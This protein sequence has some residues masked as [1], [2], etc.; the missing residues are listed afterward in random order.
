M[1]ER[2]RPRIDAHLLAGETREQQ[3]PTHTMPRQFEQHHIEKWR[4]TDGKQRFRRRARQLAETRAEPAAKD[5]RLT[6]HSAAAVGALLRGNNR[7]S[8]KPQTT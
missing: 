2:G 3:Y 8:T 7:A 6:N 4:V 5:R 1:G